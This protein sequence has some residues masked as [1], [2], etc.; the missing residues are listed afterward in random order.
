MAPDGS[1]YIADQNNSKVRRVTPDGTITTVAG[2]VSQCS[3]S[4]FDVPALQAP[5]A[6]PR[7]GF[8]KATVAPA[9]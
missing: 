1:L 9:A 2:C 4:R 8:T 7:A 3:F 5:L 6:G